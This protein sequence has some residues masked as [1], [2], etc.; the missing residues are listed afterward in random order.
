MRAHKHLLGQSR[1]NVLRSTDKQ[2]IALSN[3]S[4]PQAMIYVNHPDIAYLTRPGWP[5]SGHGIYVLDTRHLINQHQE[6]ER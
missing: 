4:S 6:S 3:Q 5:L 1:Q 2:L